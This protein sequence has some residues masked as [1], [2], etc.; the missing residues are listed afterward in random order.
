MGQVGFAKQDFYSFHDGLSSSSTRGPTA[1]L[2]EMPSTVFAAEKRAGDADEAVATGIFVAA[3]RVGRKRGCGACGGA[4]RA[5]GNVSRPE[6]AASIK[7]VVAVLP[8]AAPPID[9]SFA[10]RIRIARR[11]ILAIAVLINLR[12]SAGVVDLSLIHI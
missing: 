5:G 11:I 3:D 1:L 2:A 4:D 8:V 7:A 12:A 10:A 6:A 9:P